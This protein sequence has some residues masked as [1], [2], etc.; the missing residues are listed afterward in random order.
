MDATTATALIEGFDEQL[1]DL[2]REKEL[3]ET[4]LGIS[5]AEDIIA[6][7]RS[8]EE[9]LSALYADIATS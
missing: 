9:Q 2:Y 4:S 8:L 7:V 3:L 5:D 1:Q 6:M